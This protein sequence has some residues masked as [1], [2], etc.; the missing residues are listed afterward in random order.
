MM[1]RNSIFLPKIHLKKNQL[2]PNLHLSVPIIFN[3][4]KSLSKTL[5]IQII[6]FLPI[7]DYLLNVIFVLIVIVIP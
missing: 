7:N 1:L 5:K 6:E 2:T 4:Y 3:F